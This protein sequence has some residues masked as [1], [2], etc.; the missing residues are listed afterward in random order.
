MKINKKR[1]KFMI[2]LPDDDGHVQPLHPTQNQSTVRITSHGKISAYA[3]YINSALAKASICLLVIDT[4]L[5]QID[6]SVFAE[7]PAVCKLTT[8]LEIVK[9]ADHSGLTM[10]LEIGDGTNHPHKPS[11][12]AT[13]ESDDDAQPN[14]HVRGM[15]GSKINTS[16]TSGKEHDEAIT[17]PDDNRSNDVW[18]QATLSFASQ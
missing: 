2:P 18:M 9:R 17:P 3:N 1:R 6:I 5:K 13:R 14:K 7:G 16:T 12:G 15:Y 4:C 8:V 10:T 11:S